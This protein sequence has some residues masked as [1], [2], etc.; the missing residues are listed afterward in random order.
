MRSAKE[1]GQPSQKFHQA[2]LVIMPPRTEGFGLV[3]LEA[4]SAGLPVLVSH[5]SGLRVALEKV[6]FGRNVVVN[7]EDPAEWAKA[8]RG[9]RSKSRN[10]QLEEAR[11][12]RKNYSETYN[13]EEQCSGLIKKIRELVG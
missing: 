5:N 11:D 13:W 6:T 2:D 4:L 9:V 8:I 1:R 3:A 12:L 10:V 7:S